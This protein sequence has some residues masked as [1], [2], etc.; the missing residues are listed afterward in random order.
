MNFRKYV[1]I[2]FAFSIFSSASIFSQN[3][4]VDY[5][6]HIWTAADGLPGNTITDII[7]TKD[8]YV[9]MGTYDGLVRFDG[10][11]FNI[12]N[13]NTDENLGF[14]SAR[15]VFEDSR[16]NL[17]IG[18]ND[19]GIIKITRDG[20]EKFDSSN[21]LPNNSV[22]AIV[23]DKV[24]NIWVGT[25]SGVVFINQDGQISV[26][27]GLEKFD[28]E[29]VLVISLYC[30]T[31]GRIWL[32]TSNQGGIY[33]YS[34]RKFHRY[35]SLDYLNE[36]IG[37]YTVSA[38]GQDDSGNLI[39]GISQNGVVIIRNGTEYNI[40][41]LKDIPPCLVNQIYLDRSS[42][43]WFLTDK[44]V[45]LLRNGK[46]SKYTTSMGLTDN[47]INKILEDHEGNIWFATDHGG[48]EKLSLGKF[49]TFILN[50]GVNAICQDREE[51][52]W[53]GTD[54]GLLCYRNDEI[55]DT[56]LTNLTKGIRIR[57]VGLANNGDL[58]VSC[59]SKLGQI[60][61]TR[62]GILNWTKKDGII[63]DKVRVCTEDRDGN[64]W[65]GSTTG[66]A[67]I[68]PDGTISNFNSDQGL[69]NDY[70]MSLFVDSDNRLWVGTDGGGIDIIVNGKVTESYNTKSGLCGN[71]VF[72]ISQDENGIFWICTGTGISRFDGKY[73][74][75]FNAKDGLG[76]DSIFQ[77]LSDYTETIWITSN[78]GISSIQKSDFEKYITGEKK[79]L[80]PKFFTKNDGLKSGGVTSTSLSMR[81]SLGRL[82]FTLIDGFAV[83]DPMKASSNKIL[84]NTHIESFLVNGKNM[85]VHDNDRIIL[86][87]GVKKIDIAYT[88]LSFVSSEL[89][90]FRNMLEG[91]DHEFSDITA[92]RS[93]TYT[94]LKPGNYRFLVDSSNSDGLWSETPVS[95]AFKIKPYFY[96]VPL[97]WIAV[98]FILIGIVFLIIRIRLAA[99]KVKQLQLETM[100]Q[101]KTVD[102]E[103]EKDNSDRLLKN[104]LPDSIAERLK[105]N[106]F[107]DKTI[108]D[109]F[110]DVTVL[111]ADIVDFTK[112]TSNHSADDVVMALNDL[113]SRFDSRAKNMGVEKIKTIGDCYMAV[114]GL[115]EPREDNAQIMVDFARGMY[116]DLYE[117]NKKAK[118]PFEI[119]VGINCG[120]V[121]AGVIG[122][123]K[124]IYDIWGDTVNVASRME[125]IC[126]SGHIMVTEAVKNRTMANIAFDIV[127]EYEVKGKGKMKGFTI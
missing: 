82:Y 95:I 80:V 50:T 55:I 73:F 4:P 56:E 59:Y 15:V 112:T 86:Q 127:D 98:G 101:M 31:A 118:I 43:L 48:V 91:F 115:P 64:L 3:F 34:E 20:I 96:Q 72:K 18:S 104:I 108:A 126:K 120:P 41:A 109:R 92:L 17:W 111:F 32:A 62:E 119:R 102:L 89:V 26:P 99:L 67:R 110:D 77:M 45:Y 90:R 66:L 65:I 6:S 16:C 49:N 71:V 40:P 33:Y 107:G 39:F 11:N 103:I 23:E 57:H 63:G 35:T 10:I 105:E 28:S 125:S 78:R 27:E 113:F 47:T 29:H 69:C 9:Y 68:A 122:Q 53:I 79:K 88:G 36:T 123:T 76:T 37:S 8:G 46:I 106:I 42:N 13:R 7:Q 30:D 84:P 100:I 1:S 60:R 61:K 58:L 25:A 114:C 54:D 70:I 38:I 74:T 116:A 117:Y 52:I 5:V 22:R 21:G 93:V 51:N 12:Q 75:N 83:Y 97:F 2:I 14:S 124:F 85:G 121:I 24:G 87:P 19:E 81:D 44:G 94:N